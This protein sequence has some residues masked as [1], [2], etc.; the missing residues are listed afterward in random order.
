MSPR[1]QML[2][3]LGAAIFNID[4]PTKHYHVETNNTTKHS[5]DEL[6][7]HAGLKRFEYGSNYVYAINQ[8]NADK[9]AKKLGYVR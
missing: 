3:A 2:A 7:E 5:K 8:R 4:N 6:N 9:K 1:L